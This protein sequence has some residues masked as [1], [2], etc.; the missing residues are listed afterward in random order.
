MSRKPPLRK[1][2]LG[3]VL[4]VGGGL[5]AVGGL[6]GIGGYVIRAVEV[7]DQPDRSWLFWGLAV[8]FIG[9]ALLFAGVSLVVVGR[10]M[11]RP[12]RG[13]SDEAPRP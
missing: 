12:A 2:I 4:L 1:R 7:L 11:V 8:L 6:G 3:R 5:L 9:V 10:D 13:E